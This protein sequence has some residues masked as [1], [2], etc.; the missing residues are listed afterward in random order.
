MSEQRLGRQTP[1]DSVV[2][3][4]RDS[5]GMEAIEDYNRTGRT[6]QEWQSRMMEDIMAITQD[7]LWVHMKFGWSIPR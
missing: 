4:Y 3:P 1:T 2:L 5:L 7:G 6:A